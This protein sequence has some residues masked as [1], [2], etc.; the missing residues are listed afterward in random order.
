MRR[1][2]ERRV[3]SEREF[4]RLFIES[5][6]ESLGSVLSEVVRLAVYD[7]L[8]KHHSIA[9]NQIPERLDDFALALERC[10]GVAPS[11]TMGKVIVKRLYSK[12]GLVFVDETDWRLPDYVREAKRKMNERSEDVE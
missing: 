2:E 11:K 6:D 10:F 3:L 12:L 9:R 8:E 1:V 4:N 7:A 5:L